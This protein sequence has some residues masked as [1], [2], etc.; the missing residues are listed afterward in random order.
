MEKWWA[1]GA[2]ILTSNSRLTLEKEKQSRR[3]VAVIGGGF[4]GVAAAQELADGGAQVTLIESADRLG[5]LATGFRARGWDWSLEHFYHHWFRTDNWVQ[6]FSKRWDVLDKIV[7]K[8]PSTVM[9]TRAGDFVP[10][11]SPSALLRYRE[12]GFF[13]RVRMGVCLAYLKLVKKGLNFEDQTAESWCRRWMGDEGFEAIW[14]PLMEG[15]FG[16][17]WASR[18][19]MAWLWARLACRTPELGTF[20]GG[21][22]AFAEAA[23]A[24]LKNSGVEIHKSSRVVSLKREG[25]DWSLELFDGKELKG[26]QDVVFCCSP[27]VVNKI[28]SGIERSSKGH[29]INTLAEPKELPFLGAQVLIFALRKSIGSHYWYSLRKSREIPFLALIEHTNFLSKSHFS[30]DHLVYLADY[31]S[32]DSED[33]VRTDAD[34][35]DLGKTVLQKINPQVLESDVLDAWVFR[36]AYA[37]PVPEINHSQRVPSLSVPGFEGLWQA[38]MGHVY[39]W[40]RGTNFA[41]ELGHRVSKEVLRMK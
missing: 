21:F 24:G 9:Q 32:L 4:C 2:Q 33:W 19:N 15:K 41:L 30:N 25:S 27:L 12:L 3:K 34:L 16:L 22:L 8:R 23:E 37:Q 36:E 28:T 29:E 40:D 39:P 11:D 26:F 13:N 7:W 17:K 31:V 35:I 5:G 1:K 10:L 6:H 18:V 14:K 38:S 20:E